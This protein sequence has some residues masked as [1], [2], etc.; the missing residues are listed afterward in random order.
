M[1][2]E[3][4]A[5]PVVVAPP[6]IIEDSNSDKPPLPPRNQPE[7]DLSEV[8]VK[9]QPDTKLSPPNSPKQ[10]EEAAQEEDVS[11]GPN[12]ANSTSGDTLEAFGELSAD[13]SERSNPLRKRRRTSI[14][15]ALA[16]KHFEQ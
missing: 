10:S 3:P 11:R 8:E 16:K 12:S 13:A 1:E 7:D 6:P 9:R 14:V 5:D 4:V 2:E 15:D